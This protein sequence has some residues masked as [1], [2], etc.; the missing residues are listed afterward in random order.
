LATLSKL[1]L[2]S[3]RVYLTSQNLF[4]YKQYSGFTAELPG[5]VIGSG[6]ELSAYPTTRTIAVGLNVGF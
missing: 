3:L 4:T 2:T 5:D 1:R 6:I